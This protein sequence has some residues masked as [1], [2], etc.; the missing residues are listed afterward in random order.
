[1]R[2]IS[3]EDFERNRCVEV[4][5]VIKGFDSTEE[6]A[7][8]LL[9]FVLEETELFDYTE[10]IQSIRIE[11]VTQ[12]LNE[13]FDPARITLSIVMPMESRQEEGE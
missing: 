12:L 4:A 5:E 1:E 11:D 9:D 2:G 3:K 7:N 10:I 8:N 6:I 13:F